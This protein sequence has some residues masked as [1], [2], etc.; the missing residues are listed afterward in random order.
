MKKVLILNSY[1]DKNIGDAAILDAA[2]QFLEESIKSRLE[3][4]IQSA[5]PNSTTI[6]Y[7][8]KSRIKKVYSP[9]G[10]AIKANNRHISSMTKIIKTIDITLRTLLYVAA[11][12]IINENSIQLQYYKSIKN[13]DYI[14]SIGGGYIRTKNSVRDL[15][16]L[17]LTLLPIW[18][19][20]FNKKKVFLLPMSFGNFANNMHKNLAAFTLKNEKI[21]LRDN[22]SIKEF[23]SSGRADNSDLKMFPDLALFLDFKNTIKR[24]GS[25]NYI[26]ITAREWMSHEKQHLYE[27]S[28]AEFIKYVWSK[29]QL[30]SVFIPMTWNSS[31]DDDQRVAKR[32]GDILQS[33]HFFSI[34]NVRKPIE[35]QE[36]I[37]HS[38]MAIC[39]RMHSSILAATTNTPFFCIAYEHKTHGLLKLL[40]LSIWNIDIENVNLSELINMFEKLM[41]ERYSFIKTLNLNHTKILKQRKYLQN[42]IQIFTQ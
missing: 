8:T 30:R 2:I 18:V 4:T 32:I 21:M 38:R 13:A 1:G 28:L 36:I 26:V 16:G 41:N 39:T 19:S 24:T 10:Y 42:Q 5:T 31:E 29:H 33:P 22:M 25:K 11:P 34:S 23:K 7:K 3:I 20:K 9:Y 35:V 14:F 17:Y 27:T 40:N 37:L 12:Y 15:F 6:N